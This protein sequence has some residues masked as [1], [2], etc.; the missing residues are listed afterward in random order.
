[1]GDR[2]VEC[3]VVAGLCTL[4]FQAGVSTGLDPETHNSLGFHFALDINLLLE[5]DGKFHGGSGVIRRSD[6]KAL[7]DMIYALLKEPAERNFK[8]IG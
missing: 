8:P 1:M 4:T 3:E 2:K 5:H 6:A 7:A